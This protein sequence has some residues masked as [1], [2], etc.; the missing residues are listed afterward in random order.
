MT[1]PE[2]AEP[3]MVVLL[4]PAPALVTTNAFDLSEVPVCRV[5]TSSTAGKSVPLRF[6]LLS[7]VD[8]SLLL[9]GLK[10]DN[11]AFSGAVMAGRLGMD[12]SKL[13]FH[14]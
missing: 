9:L 3:L 5:V 10:F 8:P 1:L 2:T 13:A 7:S 4:P 6:G 11:S 12:G 14:C